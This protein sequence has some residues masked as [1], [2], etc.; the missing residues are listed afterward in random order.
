MKLKRTGMYD[1]KWDFLGW[2]LPVTAALLAVV[3]AIK[4][5]NDTAIFFA[6]A[7]VLLVINERR[8]A[9]I[10]TTSL[11]RVTDEE[12]HVRGQISYDATGIHIGLYTKF[13]HKS[14]SVGFVFG[15]GESRTSKGLY[16]L[17]PSM[18]V[19]G[20]MAYKHRSYSMDFSYDNEAEKP[21]VYIG[22]DRTD[23]IEIDGTE[24]HGYTMCHSFQLS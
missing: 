20:H 6:V 19:Y 15:Y 16:D 4:S 18:S 7:V 24:Y 23:E 2:L 14:P 5:G 11:I 13:W 12:G 3:G 8:P 22:V 10:V 1:E 9:K 17:N 21:D